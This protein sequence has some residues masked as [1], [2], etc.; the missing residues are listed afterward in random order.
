[1]YV[2]VNNIHTHTHHIYIY[3]YIHVNNIHTHTHHSTRATSDMNQ[4]LHPLL[5]LPRAPA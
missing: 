5:L 3:M 4:A 1:M 2:H